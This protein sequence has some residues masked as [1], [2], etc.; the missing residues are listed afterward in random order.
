LWNL[1]VAVQYEYGLNNLA[2]PSQRYADPV[3]LNTY[4]YVSDDFKMNQ[5]RFT[6]GIVRTFAYPKKI[7]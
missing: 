5:F 3:L 1:Q 4:A 2:N 6:V 7:N